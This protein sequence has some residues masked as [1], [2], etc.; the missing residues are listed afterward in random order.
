MTASS[1][2]RVDWRARLLTQCERQIILGSDGA[3]HPD[4]V[5]VFDVAVRFGR[6]RDSVRQLFFCL[7]SAMLIARGL[8][9]YY[10]EGWYVLTDRG[11]NVRQALLAD[12]RSEITA[13]DSVLSACCPGAAHRNDAGRDHE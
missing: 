10:P 2:I 3:R 5:N 1:S 6:K 11:E 7:H 13:R 8:I 12:R 9:E 4:A